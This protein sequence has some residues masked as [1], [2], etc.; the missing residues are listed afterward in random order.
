M[1]LVFLAADI[2]FIRMKTLENLLQLKTADAWENDIQ[3]AISFLISE[4]NPETFIER[5]EDIQQILTT[6]EELRAFF[7]CQP[8]P[9]LFFPE[10]N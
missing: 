6:L 7:K 1:R 4:T 8:P 10:K 9:L 3:K 5:A 2:N